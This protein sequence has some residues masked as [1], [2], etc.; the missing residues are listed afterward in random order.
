MT[1]HLTHELVH[2][3]FLEQLGSSKDGGSGKDTE[4]DGSKT[5][6]TITVIVGAAIT[7]TGAGSLTTT[8]TSQSI[9]V[10][11]VARLAAR[12]IFVACQVVE[13]LAE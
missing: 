12:D 9:L 4:V 11:V 3:L 10:V 2:L 7:A 6:S 5:S 1:P 8:S 13:V